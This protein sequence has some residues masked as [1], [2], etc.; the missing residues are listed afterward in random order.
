MAKLFHAKMEEMWARSMAKVDH[1]PRRCRTV[2]FDRL[3]GRLSEVL[4]LI[5]V[6]RIASTVARDLG[7]LVQLDP[8]VDVWLHTFEGVDP[9]P[10]DTPGPK[11]MYCYRATAPDWG[12]VICRQ[13]SL[14]KG[15]GSTDRFEIVRGADGATHFRDLNGR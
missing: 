9:R 14:A 6:D 11:T 8:E 13:Y 1:V 15:S 10:R 12:R 7:D 2:S 5:K 4:G 3:Q